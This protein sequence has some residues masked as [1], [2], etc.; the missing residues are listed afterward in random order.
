MSPTNCPVC[1]HTASVKPTDYEQ[2]AHVDCPCCGTYDLVEGAIRQMR[3]EHK[4]RLSYKI[5]KMQSSTTPPPMIDSDLA[6]RLVADPLPS[7]REQSDNFILWVGGELRQ[8]N[9]A[10]YFPL[11]LADVRAI[12]P[13]KIGAFNSKSGWVIVSDYLATEELVKLKNYSSNKPEVQITAKGWD[14]YEE[15][16]RSVVE[17]RIA[18]MAMPFNDGQLNRV[19]EECF[20]PAVEA[21]GFELRRLIDQQKA[22]IIDDQMRVMIRRARFTIAE[23]THGNKG[24]YWEAGFAEGLNRP[25]IYTCERSYFD[26]PET[27]PHFDINHC[28]TI[29]WQ[30]NDLHK[31]AEE[32]KVR[33]RATLPDE[34]KTSD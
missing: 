2:R 15:L 13:A 6:Q 24:A 30:T 14:R 33:I 21:T 27:K 1:G 25:V 29:I 9:P 4:P 7:V 23:L 17:S 20:K 8:S 31:A 16:R 3:P 10:G 34:A 19:F 11:Y 28:S 32:L 22:G 26:S 5:R 18:F 12:L